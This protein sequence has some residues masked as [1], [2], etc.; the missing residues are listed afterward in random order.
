MTSK[1]QIKTN[2][3]SIEILNKIDALLLNL[4]KKLSQ[5]PKI[6]F[7]DN[8]QFC[9]LMNISKGTAS[10]WRAIKLIGYSQINNKYYY[11]LSDILDMLQYHYKPCV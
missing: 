4:D 6:V 1:D 10:N 7:F 11:R 9:L 8:Q 2:T 5:D 3:Q